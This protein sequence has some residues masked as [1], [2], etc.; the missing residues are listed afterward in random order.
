VVRRERFAHLRERCSS[1]DEEEE[2]EAV[3]M[4]PD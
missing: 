3:M 1:V 2:E 4:V